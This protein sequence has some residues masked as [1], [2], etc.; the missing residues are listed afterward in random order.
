MAD[1]ADPQQL[2]LGLLDPSVRADPYPLYRQILEQSPVTEGP[3]GIVV[4]A[5]YHEIDRLLRDRRVSSD[6]RNS[7]AFR[8]WL[9]EQGAD[10]DAW[11]ADDAQPFLLRDPPD[12]TRLRRLA[13]KAFSVRAVEA[14]R[15]R[16]AALVDDLLDRAA[17]RGDG[18]IE[19][20]EDLAYPLPVTVISELLGVPPED[21]ATFKRWSATLAQSIDPPFLLSPEQ[22]EAQWHAVDEFHAYFRELIARRRVEP[23]D[24]LLSALVSVRDAGD[25]LTE[26]ELLGTCVLLLA[27]GHETTVNLIANATLALLRHPDQFA[28]LAEDPSTARGAVEEALR[29]DPPVQLRDR[30]ALEPLTVGDV[31]VGEGQSLLLLLAAGNRDATRFA[32][33]DRFDVTRDASGHLAFGAGIHYCLGAP[34]ARIEGQVALTAL[35]R[36]LEAPELATDDLIYTSNIALRGLQAL[37]VSARR[38]RPA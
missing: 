38:I 32:H 4:V 7:T 35:A 26:D 6:Y 30:V 24:D 36:R 25:Q 21:D 29:Y 31:E 8:Q 10:L 33:P 1:L 27:A 3:M 20:I 37:P 16:I 19:L 14:Q 5:S 9:A 18:Q 15:P 28:R 2:L 12:H 11:D 13:A 22:R 34:L 23:G 17:A